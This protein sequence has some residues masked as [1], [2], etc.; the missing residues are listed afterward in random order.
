MANSIRIV[1]KEA[2]AYIPVPYIGSS[3]YKVFNELDTI[4]IKEDWAG[5]HLHIAM[6]ESRENASEHSFKFDELSF[7][8]GFTACLKALE[9]L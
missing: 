2:V 5:K 9:G 4:E 6:A 1:K 8:A 3:P 7:E